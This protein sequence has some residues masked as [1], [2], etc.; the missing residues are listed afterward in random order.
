MSQSAPGANWNNISMFGRGPTSHRGKRAAFPGD[1]VG[2]APDPPRKQVN[3]IS[4]G[5]ALSAP[6]F[7]VRSRPDQP[8]EE[9][10]DLA[11]DPRP[12]REHDVADVARHQE[13]GEHR[14]DLRGSFNRCVGA[15]LEVLRDLSQR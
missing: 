14:Q 3:G 9:L 10:E 13:I 5:D 1:A 2:T 15:V 4:E 8:L 6:L 12:H 7:T 11:V